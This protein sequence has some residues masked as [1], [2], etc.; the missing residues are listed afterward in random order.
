MKY[1]VGSVFSRIL[2]IIFFVWYFVKVG[3]ATPEV[4]MVIA[5]S[6]ILFSIHDVLMAILEH[7]K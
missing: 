5:F 6:L 7:L 1:Q 3:E 4:I 2:S